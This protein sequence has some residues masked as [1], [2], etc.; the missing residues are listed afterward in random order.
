MKWGAWKRQAERKAILPSTRIPD[1]GNASVGINPLSHAPALPNR[2]R[3][4]IAFGL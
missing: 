1:L 2:V 3:F 4:F